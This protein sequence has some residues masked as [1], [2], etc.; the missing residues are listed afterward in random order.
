MYH[1]YNSSSAGIIMLG[2]NQTEQDYQVTI[3]SGYMQQ[4]Q[5][6]HGRNQTTSQLGLYGLPNSL[7]QQWSLTSSRSRCSCTRACS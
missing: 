1:L 6:Y 5:T 4:Q 7:V 3:P 2:T